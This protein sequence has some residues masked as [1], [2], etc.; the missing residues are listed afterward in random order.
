MYQRNNKRF[1]R[2]AEKRSP[3]SS[4]LEMLGFLR[5]P[6]LHELILIRIRNV[7]SN[8]IPGDN[9]L[10]PIVILSRRCSAPPTDL[11]T[12]SG[13]QISGYGRTSHAVRPKDVLVDSAR[14]STVAERTSADYLVARSPYFYS[15]RRHR[16]SWAGSRWNLALSG[17]PI[18]CESDVASIGDGVCAISPQPHLRSPKTWAKM[19]TRVAFSTAMR[20]CVRVKRPTRA[21]WKTLAPE[22][23]AER[24]LFVLP[25]PVEPPPRNSF[26]EIA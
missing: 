4:R 9:G 1:F 18:F 17:D 7:I 25:K 24:G 16:R 20:T 3:T 26:L 13:D 10:H 19:A 22:F 5:Q 12:H 8:A 21:A 6:N 14:A 11:R 23:N 2:L 15:T